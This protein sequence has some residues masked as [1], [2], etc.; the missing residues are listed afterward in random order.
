MPLVSVRKKSLHAAEQ[1]VSRRLKKLRDKD[2]EIFNREEKI[3]DDKER[4]RIQEE[5]LCIEKERLQSKEEALRIREERLQRFAPMFTASTL[6]L[7]KPVNQN[8]NCTSAVRHHF[9]TPS[10]SSEVKVLV[11][12]LAGEPSAESKSSQGF[13]AP[14]IDEIFY[15]IIIYPSLNTKCFETLARKLR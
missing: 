3:R 1:R 4:L 7:A 15:N 8:K 5:R 11:L 2:N 14:P 6:D 10:S 12:E 13:G 9:C